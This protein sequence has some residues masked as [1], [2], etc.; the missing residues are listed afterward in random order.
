M[1][2]LLGEFIPTTPQQI[3]DRAP[4]RPCSTPVLLA[5]SGGNDSRVLA[6]VMKY[7]GLHV[8]LAAIDTGLS[9]DG[10]RQSVMEF[11]AWIDLPVSFWQGEGVDYYRAYVEAHGFPGNAMHSQVQNR[12][13]GRAYRKMFYAR[14]TGA[15]LEMKA[16]GVGLW[17]LSGIR[18]GESRKR[19]LLKSPY[20]WRDGVLFINPLFYWSNSKV[21]DYMIDHNIPEAPG[22]QWD[23]KC[24]ATVKDAGN[25]WAEI[26][27]KAPALCGL[28]KSLYNPMPWEWGQFDKAAHGVTQQVAAGQQWL[29]DG[30]MEAFPTCVNC[31]RDL[32]ADEAAGVEDW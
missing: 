14:R 2:N 6:H 29:D 23:C 32:L 15:E 30:S 9:M 26:E 24:G 13:K 27:G 18:K 19:E 11:A 28:L 20:S 31:V 22:K 12:L 3:I 25:E 21:I 5:F 8:E 4:L 16:A 7:A 17:I 1:K 10:W